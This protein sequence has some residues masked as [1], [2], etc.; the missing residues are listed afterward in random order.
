MYAFK[1]FTV[2]YCQTWRGHTMFRC[3][4]TGTNNNFKFSFVPLKQLS[5]QD[6]AAPSDEEA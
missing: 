3:T 6:L 2:I 4:K 1:G 5:V